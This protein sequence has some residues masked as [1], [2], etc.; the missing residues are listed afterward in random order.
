VQPGED[1]VHVSTTVTL[2]ADPRASGQARRLVRDLCSAARLDGDTS[3][4][5]ALLTSELVTNAVLHGRSEVEMTVSIPGTRLR[6]SV[7]DENSRGP[8]PQ[9]EDAEALDGRGLQ[10]LSLLAAA[11]GV[12]PRPLGKAVWFELDVTGAQSGL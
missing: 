11:W 4:T 1:H 10:I 12:E 8:Q 3:D 5:A 9:I 2:H 6:V 7:A